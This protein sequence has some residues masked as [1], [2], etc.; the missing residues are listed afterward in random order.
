MKKL[1]IALW[2]VI[3]FPF[4]LIFYIVA[5]PFRLASTVIIFLNSEPDDRP[6]IDTFTNLV[7]EQEARSSFWDHIEELRAHLLRIVIGLVILFVIG[8]SMARRD[9]N[10]P[11]PHPDDVAREPW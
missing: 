9:T 11:G 5:L 10:R 4:R 8:F 1:S 3:T 2:R 6:L 7:S